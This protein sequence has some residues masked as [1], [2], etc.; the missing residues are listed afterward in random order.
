VPSR[1][2]NPNTFRLK[3]CVNF[4]DVVNFIT[5]MPNQ[6]NWDK[7]LFI[8]TCACTCMYMQLQDHMASHHQVTELTV[9]PGDTCPFHCGQQVSSCNIHFILIHYPDLRLIYG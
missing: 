1:I 6:P 2:T 9:S 8:L 4:V 5:S 7:H 3:F